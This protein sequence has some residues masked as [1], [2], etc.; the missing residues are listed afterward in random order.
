ML[1]CLGDIEVPRYV[2]DVSEISEIPSLITFSFI[3]TGTMKWITITNK[4][5][6]FATFTPLQY[7]I[8]SLLS[9]QCLEFH[10]QYTSESMILFFN[11]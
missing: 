6:L 1:V 5:F 7:A 3:G 2:L 11:L 8:P 4:S 9:L 10:R